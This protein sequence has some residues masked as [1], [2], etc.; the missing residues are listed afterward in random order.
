MDQ[1]KKTFL[2]GEDVRV[3]AAESSFNQEKRIF[4]LIL[5]RKGIFQK[6]IY[7]S[8][9]E[10]S[11]AEVAMIAGKKFLMDLRAEAVKAT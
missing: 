10:F 2:D 9:Q 8:Q 6:V 3:F 7:Q 11:N 5:F 1:I 4:L